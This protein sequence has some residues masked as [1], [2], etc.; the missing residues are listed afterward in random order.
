MIAIVVALFPTVSVALFGTA[1]N[2]REPAPNA[3]DTA[4]GF[5]VGS[6][7]D[8][9]VVR[10]THI[11]GD[12][13]GIEEI[14]IIVRASGPSADL[15]TGVR[16]VDFPGDG[17]QP[18]NLADEDIQGLRGSDAPIYNDFIHQEGSFFFAFDYAGDQIII[19]DDSDT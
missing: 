6:D 1:E 4:G 7:P 8:K 17:T 10:I 15:P 5:E 9:Q 11:P 12:S 13:I 14:E 16:L 19:A 2:I 18:R 3:A